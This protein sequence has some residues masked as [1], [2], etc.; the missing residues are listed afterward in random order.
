MGDAGDG[1]GLV[2]HPNHEPRAGIPGNPQVRAQVLDGDGT[3]ED[4][5]VGEKHAA[6]ASL[7]E[8]PY[9]LV[10]PDRRRQVGVRD[11]SEGML[12]RVEAEGGLDMEATLLPEINP[13]SVK[14]HLSDGFF[15]ALIATIPRHGAVNAQDG[16][17]L[18]QPEE[19]TC[20][21]TPMHAPSDGSEKH[22][23][24]RESV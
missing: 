21:R 13:A 20:A 5:I 6:H 22:L 1:V 14:V 15:I 16:V 10:A 4:G 11:V 8:H 17:T 3:V 24:I 7:A 18:P 12:D 19:K 2:T 23:V 9:N